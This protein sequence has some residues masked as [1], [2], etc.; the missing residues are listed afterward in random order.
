MEPGE[1]TQYNDQPT[2]RM[3]L[4]WFPTQTSLHHSLHTSS[5]SHKAIYVMAPG[6]ILEGQ[7]AD[8]LPLSCAEFKIV[9]YCTSTPP[10]DFRE[11]CWIKHRNIVNLLQH[12]KCHNNT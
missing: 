4:I 2:S 10:C 11:C 7:E 5:G 12:T 6:V 3:A 9:F 1:F 8:N